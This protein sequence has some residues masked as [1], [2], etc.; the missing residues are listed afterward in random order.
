MI[1]QIYP[2]NSL[3]FYRLIFMAWLIF[4]EALFLF[5]FERKKHFLIKL[6]LVLL[7]CL[8]LL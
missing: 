1:E 6:P 8:F 3:F 4:G 7:S 2:L 5:K